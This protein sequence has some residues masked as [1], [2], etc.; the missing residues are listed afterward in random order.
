[1]LKNFISFFNPINFTKINYQLVLIIVNIFLVIAF[2]QKPIRTFLSTDYPPK[3]G[4]T[5]TSH[6]YSGHIVESGMHIENFHEFDLTNNKFVLN[7]I[8]WFK[9]NPSIISLDTIEKFSFEKGDILYKSKP[10]QK[11]IGNLVLA[12]FRIKFSFTSNLDYKLFPLSNHR[13][14]IT[15]T[16]KS[17]S[18]K[19]LLFESYE[20]D[21]SLS[22]N[23][24]ISGWKKDDH[25]VI[26]GHSESQLDRHD[27]TTKIHHPII[28]FSIDF[29]QSGIR[30]LIVL[31]IPLFF[32]FYL[33]IFSISLGADSYGQGIGI[34]LGNISAFIGYRFVV[35]GVSPK[36][37]YLM[38]ID[39]V[40]NLLL[41]I[42][43]LIFF[44]NLALNKQ[45]YALMARG[46]AIICVHT[47]FLI[48][49]YYL[50]HHWLFSM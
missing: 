8:V 48:S 24:R 38:F 40:F 6:E 14:F 29:I 10:I 17:V 16:N 11:L 28:V 36:V 42:A 18:P 34:S 15:L 5:E 26:T 4:H 31:F 20:S 9:F 13:I 46:I 50:C 32:M 21:L 27:P 22:E 25:G 43:F 2:L 30:Q 49:W 39:H 45:K 7:A 19:D 3:I 12:Q 1:M 44:I 33:A 37:G 47:F 23:M 35:E 41:F